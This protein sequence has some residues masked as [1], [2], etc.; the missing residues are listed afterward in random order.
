[1]PSQRSYFNARFDWSSQRLN[2]EAYILHPNKTSKSVLHNLGKLSEQFAPESFP[3]NDGSLL[4]KAICSGRDEF[5]IDSNVS[6]SKA[7][8]TAPHRIPPEEHE[9]LGR[10]KQIRNQH[11]IAEIGP[12]DDIDSWEVTLNSHHFQEPPKPEQKIRC[13]IRRMVNSIASQ[14]QI[15]VEIIDD[16]PRRDLKEFGIDK[17]EWLHWASQIDV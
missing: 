10:I 8:G 4:K 6:S 9:Y 11:V 2:H 17:E 3:Q 15:Q 1:M 7:T 12:P 14:V 5:S 13:K 16:E